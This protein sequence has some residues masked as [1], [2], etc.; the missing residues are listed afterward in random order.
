MRTYDP[1][2]YTAPHERIE[3]ARR[4]EAASEAREAALEAK[5]GMPYDKLPAALRQLPS[6]S[7]AQVGGRRFDYLTQPT[8]H[9][10]ARARQYRRGTI[11]DRNRKPGWR[12]VR[13]A[14]L[15]EVERVRQA[16]I[17]VRKLRAVKKGRGKPLPKNH[18]AQRRDAI[19]RREF[20]EKSW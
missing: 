10:Y 1:P 7:P 4:N 3:K 5:Y 13:A 18:F 20:R 17:E 9:F 12:M 16:E 8:F 2:P 6:T 15:R 19:E 11:R 14:H